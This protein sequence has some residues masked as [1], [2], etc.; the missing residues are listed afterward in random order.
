MVKKL[1]VTKS[2][3]EHSPSI[4][5]DELNNFFINVPIDISGAA[6]YTQELKAQPNPRENLFSF[7]VVNEFDV[8]KAIS[9]TKSNAIGADDISIKFIKEI[10]P[11][12]LPV[13]TA[14]FNKSLTTSKFPHQW[15]SAIVRPSQKSANPTTP[16]DYRP[17][18]ILPALSKCLERIVHQQFCHF[19]NQNNIISVYQS[20]FRKN[21]STTSVLLC[22]TDDIRKA[23]DKM[24]VSPWAY[25]Q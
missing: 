3:P 12:V 11:A 13:I 2:K 14:I 22:I 7:H 20:G 19:L 23:M 1:G 24:G 6:A 4:N 5:L 8:L 25:A 16:A 17:I 9:A 15:K 10:L 18:S 21:H